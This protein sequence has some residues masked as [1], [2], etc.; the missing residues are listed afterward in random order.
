MELRG[1]QRYATLRIRHVAGVSVSLFLLLLLLL[2][3]VPGGWSQ[4][5]RVLAQGRDEVGGRRSS[6]D[7][8]HRSR[9]YP[10]GAEQELELS[11]RVCARTYTM[12]CGRV[13]HDN[14]AH[15]FLV[16]AAAF[17]T[18]NWLQYNKVQRSECREQNKKIPTGE[19]EET[20]GEGVLTRPDEQNP[21]QTNVNGEATK[22]MQA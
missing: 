10:R 20:E 7:F 12:D 1:Q 16:L 3:A 14:M 15:K 13:G 8:W 11:S 6:V 17:A 19:V 2:C 9:H 18:A 21:T 4:W 22:S 5:V